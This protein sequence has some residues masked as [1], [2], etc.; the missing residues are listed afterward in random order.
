MVRFYCGMSSREVV[1]TN[2]Y[3]L[4]LI[5][6]GIEPDSTVSVADAIHSTT[7]LLKGLIRSSSR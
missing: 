3:G 7:D 2:F 4:G 5:R 1:N 6:P